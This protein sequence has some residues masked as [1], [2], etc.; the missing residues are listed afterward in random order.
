MERVKALE[1]KNRW[2]IEEREEIQLRRDEHLR[3]AHLHTMGPQSLKL[4]WFTT[5]I[6]IFRLIF[7]ILK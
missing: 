3:A 1:I 2:I 5:P 4:L 6:A 7:S